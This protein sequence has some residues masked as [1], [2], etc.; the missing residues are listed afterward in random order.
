MALH[1]SG[2]ATGALMLYLAPLFLTSTFM[3]LNSQWR[4]CSPSMGNTLE[5]FTQPSRNTLKSSSTTLTSPLIPPLMMP[6]FG[7]TIRMMR[8]IPKVDTLG[9]CPT[10]I[11]PLLISLVVLGRGFGN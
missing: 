5:F 11:H 7:L 3:I 2:I 9:S 4:M 6:L 8:T 10:Q 1:P